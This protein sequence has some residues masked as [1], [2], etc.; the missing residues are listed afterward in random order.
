[1][2]NKD[3]GC[4]TAGKYMKLCNNKRFQNFKEVV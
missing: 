4:D 1:M 3:A 2:T